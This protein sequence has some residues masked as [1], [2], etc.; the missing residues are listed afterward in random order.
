MMSAMRTWLSRPAAR[1]VR[2]ARSLRTPS[3]MINWTSSGTTGLTI[4][5]TSTSLRASRGMRATTCAASAGVS[6][7]RM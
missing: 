7:D 3:S 1:A 4:I 2:L 6:F 5:A